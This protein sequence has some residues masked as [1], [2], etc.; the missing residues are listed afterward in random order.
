MLQHFL[1]TA[2]GAAVAVVIFV[3]LFKSGKGMISDGNCFHL[4]VAAVLADHVLTAHFGTGGGL[5]NG[6]YDPFVVFGGFLTADGTLALMGIF[7][8]RFPL[9]IFMVLALGTLFLFGLAAAGTLVAH[10]AGFFAGSLFLFAAAVP[11]VVQA[12]LVAA[13]A[14]LMLVGCGQQACWAIILS[15]LY[16]KQLSLRLPKVKH[17]KTTPAT[18]LINQ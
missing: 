18:G 11:G 12:L 2:A 4:G 6:F 7:I 3:H 5:G 9:F 8:N 15:A 17:R 10:E 14:A 13:D 16:S 1:Q